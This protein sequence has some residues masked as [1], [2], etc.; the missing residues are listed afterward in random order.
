MDILIIGNGPAGVSAALYVARAGI[1][2]TI[3][4]KDYGSLVKAE[5]IENYYGFKD[6]ITGQ[7]LVMSGI[8]QAKRLGVEILNEEVL[9]LGFENGFKV[10]TNKASYDAKS[11]IIATGSQRNAP[12][13][14]GIDTFEGK[15]IS[16]CA[17][18]DAFFYRKKDGWESRYCHMQSMKRY[19]KMQTTD[20]MPQKRSYRKYINKLRRM[21]TNLWFQL[22]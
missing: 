17:V 13:I 20:Q 4:G 5:K 1:K 7:D 21:N 15:G 11:V 12:K 8:E 14:A 3:I 9:N 18:C 22:Y 2:A 10:L 6:P 16:Y 19:I